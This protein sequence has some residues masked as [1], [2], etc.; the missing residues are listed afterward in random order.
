MTRPVTPGHS[1]CRRTG[2]RANS[3][4]FEAEGWRMAVVLKA[5]ADPLYQAV[6]FLP[7]RAAPDRQNVAYICAIRPGNPITDRRS[8]PF[9]AAR[10]R[11]HRPWADPS[12]TLP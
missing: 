5:S 11:A 12:V 6:V 3:G 1:A 8:G 4:D 7:V 2:N 10:R 9:L